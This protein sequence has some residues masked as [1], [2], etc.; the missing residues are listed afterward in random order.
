MAAATASAI[1][2]ISYVRGNLSPGE[3]SHKLNDFK[4]WKQS[5]ALHTTANYEYA[6]WATVAGDAQNVRR[7]YKF[8]HMW[9]LFFV[10]LPLPLSLSLSRLFYILQKAAF[11]YISRTPHK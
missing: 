8:Y 6:T 5:L 1:S 4:Y 2:L 11:L 3:F 10:P 7:P 9:V